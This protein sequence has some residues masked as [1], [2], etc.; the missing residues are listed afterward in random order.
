MAGVD[1]EGHPS[2]WLSADGSLQEEGQNNIVKQIWLKV[3][4]DV[5]VHFHGGC[6]KVL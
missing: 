6:P 5:I 2:F 1:C 4:F 3:H